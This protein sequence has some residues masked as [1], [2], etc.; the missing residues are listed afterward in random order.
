MKQPCIVISDHSHLMGH[1]AQLL[2]IFGVIVKHCLWCVNASIGEYIAIFVHFF[3]FFGRQIY[4]SI[5]TCPR[6]N[7]LGGGDGEFR[8]GIK[9]KRN[10]TQIERRKTLKHKNISQINQ[11]DYKTWNRKVK[12]E[13]YKDEHRKE[14]KGR[15]K[16]AKVIL[17]G[18]YSE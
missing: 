8:V 1:Q 14:G 11:K 17:S 2:P 13:I 15:K 9:L 18:K 4:F 12:V 5:F 10:E 16:K 7:M 6:F 3:S